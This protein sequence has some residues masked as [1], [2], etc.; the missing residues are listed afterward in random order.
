[1]IGD[2]FKKIVNICLHYETNFDKMIELLEQINTINEISMRHSSN[3]DNNRIA[4]D[5]KI[6]VAFDG[7]MLVT[8][9]RIQIYTAVK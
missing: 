3:N 4:F 9:Q 6:D 2:E 1:M 8:D 7:T 5:I